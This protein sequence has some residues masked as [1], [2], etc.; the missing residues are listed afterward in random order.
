MTNSRD[1]QGEPGHRAPD[2]GHEPDPRFT[3]ANERTFLAWNRTALAL[4]VAGLGRAENAGLLG[5]NFFRIGDVEYD[6][7][8]GMIRLMRAKGCEGAS[9]IHSLIYRARESV[10]ETPSFELWDEAPASKAKL[11]V[12]DECSM[13]DEELGRDLKSFGVPLLVLG[14]P[15]QLPPISGPSSQ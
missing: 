7:G 3:L 4:V 9:T 8:K 1:G 11:I 2:P 15:A 5:Q 6:L 10:A 14:D 13:V 12:I